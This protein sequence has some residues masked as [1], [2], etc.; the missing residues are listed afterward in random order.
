M[1]V[2]VLDVDNHPGFLRELAAED[3][4]LIRVFLNEFESDSG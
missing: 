1:L 2:F 4:D 3:G